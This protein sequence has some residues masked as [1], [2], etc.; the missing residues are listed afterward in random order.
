MDR[1]Y[2][3]LHRLNL[4]L[5]R[6]C[7]IYISL[8][9]GRDILMPH[10][11]RE[12]QTIAID[13]SV[14]CWVCQFVCRC[15]CTLQKPLDRL[16]SC[17]EWRLMGSKECIEWFP[18]DLMQ[19]LPI[20]FDHLFNLDIKEAFVGRSLFSSS[21]SSCRGSDA[22]CKKLAVYVAQCIATPSPFTERYNFVSERV[23]HLP[24]VMWTNDT[25]GISLLRLCCLQ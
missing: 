23:P 5:S 2:W 22:T 1:W 4:I 14:A 25:V 16:R 8:R 21:F 6:V 13:V 3:W 10:R 17:L 15:A 12:M 19:S 18:A 11:M 24:R 9:C 20:Y 7:R